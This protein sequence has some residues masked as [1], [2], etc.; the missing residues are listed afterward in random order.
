MAEAPERLT[1]EQK[2]ALKDEAGKLRTQERL[3]AR[4]Q[5]KSTQGQLLEQVGDLK[6][7]Y[8]LSAQA[9]LDHKASVH[10]NHPREKYCERCWSALRGCICS[11][12]KPIQTRHRYINWLHY[13]EVWRTTNTGCLLPFSCDNARTLIYGKQ[14]DD[15]ELERVLTEESA[16]TVFLYPSPE[17]ISVRL[18]IF[19]PFILPFNP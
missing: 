16:N 1:R 14:E 4:H 11:S 5:Y 3:A 12:L 19:Y 2:K 17:S 10:R 8:Q 18:G 9:F 13:K 7:R 15:A 6:R